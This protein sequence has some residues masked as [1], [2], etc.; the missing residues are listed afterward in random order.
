MNKIAKSFRSQVLA[1][2]ATG[3]LFAI[4]DKPCAAQRSSTKSNPAHFD[5]VVQKMEGWTV[6]VDPKLLEGKHAEEGG[7]A[8][9]MLANHLQR[10]AVLL[11]PEKLKKV[12]GLEIWIEHDHAIDVEPGPYHPGVGWLTQRGYDPRLAK[13]VHVTRAASLLERHHM[14]KHPAVVLHELAHSYHDQVLGFNEP[15]IRGS[16]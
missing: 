13:K 3:F 11:P 9:K 7:R 14:F 8:L 10:I 15:R 5:P 12:R 4:V 16:I 1:V 2:A 6:H